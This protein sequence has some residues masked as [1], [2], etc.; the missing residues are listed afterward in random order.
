MAGIKD[1]EVWMKP[2]K[3]GFKCYVDASLAG[4]WT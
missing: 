1:K 3:K 2:S 4:E